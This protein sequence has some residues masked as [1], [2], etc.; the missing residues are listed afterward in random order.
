VR[1]LPANDRAGLSDFLFIFFSDW[2]YGRTPSKWRIRRLRA[3]RLYRPRADQSRISCTQN[4]AS[5][6]FPHNAPSVPSGNVLTFY[7]FPPLNPF[8]LPQHDLVSPLAGE[9]WFS[10]SVLIGILLFG[11]AIFFFAFGLLPYWFK[12]HKHLSEILGCQYRP[13]HPSFRLSQRARS[14]DSRSFFP[15]RLGP[16]VSER[17]LDLESARARRH[18]SNPGLLRPAHYHGRRNVRRLGGSLWVDRARLLE[19]PNLPRGR[20]RRS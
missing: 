8:S 18:P 3:S 19:R 7:V 9:I 20:S 11:L 2:V 16:D 14:C 17:G 5:D 1:L 10:S 12:V 15:P 4:V 6:P 13:L